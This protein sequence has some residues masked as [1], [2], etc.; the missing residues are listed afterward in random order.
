[1]SET[2]YV[3]ENDFANIPNGCR[4]VFEECELVGYWQP[5]TIEVKPEPT[6]EEINFWL[7][8]PNFAKRSLERASRFLASLGS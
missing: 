7:Q 6:Q 1:M 8:E 4:P 3:E 2:F 5:E